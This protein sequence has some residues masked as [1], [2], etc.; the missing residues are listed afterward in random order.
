MHISDFF[1]KGLDT[2]KVIIWL[3]AV[4]KCPVCGGKYNSKNYKVLSS[5]ENEIYQEAQILIHSDCP[6]CKSSVMFNVDITPMEVLSMGMVT[7]LTHDDF[8]RFKKTKAFSSNDLIEIHK[9]IQKINTFD[10]SS[11][12]AKKGLDK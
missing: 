3:S 9:N 8:S 7:D 12:F 2:K 4:L 5:M 11:F 10:F 6:S 1:S